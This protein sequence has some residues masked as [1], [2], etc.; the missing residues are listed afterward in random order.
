MIG[1][2]EIAGVF[3]PMALVTG[4]VA[5]VFSLLLRRALRAANAYDYVWHAGL[6]DVAGFVVIWWL[7]ADIGRIVGMSG[8]VS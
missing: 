8:G 2:V 6:F 3:L 5:F 7:V 1:E 4:A